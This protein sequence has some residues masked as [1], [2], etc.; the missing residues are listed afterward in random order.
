MSNPIIETDLAT[1]LRE[2][3]VKLDGINEIKV[4]MLTGLNE[5]KLDVAKLDGKIETLNGRFE[6]LD[7]RVS[8][9][10]FTNRGVLIGLIVVIF[11]G[12][13]KLFLMP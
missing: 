4:N 12:F 13:A 3:N 2:I 5:I 7:K 6:Q 10:E 11:G 9:V 1:V 8:S